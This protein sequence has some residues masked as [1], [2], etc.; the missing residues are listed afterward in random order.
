MIL[1]LSNEQADILAQQARS[2]FPCEVCGLLVGKFPQ[3]Q[4]V[5]PITNIAS[6]PQNYFEMDPRE[7]VRAM[8]TIEQQRLELLAIYHSH[9]RTDPLPSSVDIQQSNYPDAACVIIGLKGSSAHL[10]AWQIKRGEIDRIPLHIGSAP[11]PTTEDPLSNAQKTAIII[12]LILAF[13]FTI[14]MAL[15]LLP[16]APVIPK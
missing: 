13:G 4:Q 9:P 5:I 7:F 3:V 16:P 1:W 8:F 2:G 12:S 10:A 6:D 11:P 15:S 14:M